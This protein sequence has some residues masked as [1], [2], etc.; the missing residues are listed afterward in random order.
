[1]ETKIPPKI[2][3][4]LLPAGWRVGVST[5]QVGGRRRL[6]I[7]VELGYGTEGDP[8]IPPNVGLVMEVELLG[9]EPP[10]PWPPPTPVEGI[11]PVT[12]PAGLTYWDLEEGYGRSPH[13]A[14]TILAH[15]TG[16]L[17]D[18]TMY[19]SSLEGERQV[20]MRLSEEIAG[21]AH[22][23]RTMKVGGKRQLKVPPELAYGEKG[24]PGIVRIHRV[25]MWQM[26]S[27]RQ[28]RELFRGGVVGHRERKRWCSIC[29]NLGS[30]SFA[31]DGPAFG[32]VMVEKPT[33]KG[34]S[35]T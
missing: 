9:V 16:W 17:S 34:E 15:L 26:P 13:R 24:R 31:F 35:V 20:A 18:G 8:Y 3:T 21:L 5:M 6:E 2:R 10:E 25:G 29:A 4:D 33:S 12:T 14:G 27:F 22:G 28:G 32:R 11:E 30:V 7:P 23:I 1:M 19:E